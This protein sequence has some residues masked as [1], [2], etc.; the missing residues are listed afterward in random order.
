MAEQTLFYR[1]FGSATGFNN[2]ITTGSGVHGRVGFGNLAR[3]YAALNRKNMRHTDNKGYPLCYVV[4]IEAIGKTDQAHQI[5]IFT[6]PETWVLKNAVRKWHAARNQMLERVDQLGKVGEYGKTIRPYLTVANAT[7]GYITPTLGKANH[8]TTYTGGGG[9]PSYSEATSAAVTGTTMNLGEWTHTQIAASTDHEDQAAGNYPVDT[10][11]LVLTGD[12]N[13]NEGSDNSGARQFS[14][15]SMMR[16]YLESR[17]NAAAI[18]Q[19]TDGQ[20]T[21]QA[22][23]NPLINLMSDR[24]SVGEVKEIVQDMQREKPPYDLFTATSD[25]A[26]STNDSLD[27]VN[28]CLLST[29]TSY[30][31][32]KEV[33]RIPMGLFHIR[34]SASAAIGSTSSVPEMRIRLLGIDKCQG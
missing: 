2:P 18:I 1:E 30:L 16:S 19:T 6:A 27:L 23:P 10:Y 34:A 12:H 8:E 13:A 5:E 33:I 4:E 21:I 24:P 11:N 25:N 31:K 3:D 15:V 26:L 22:E 14:H 7:Q 32:D 9:S 20:G 29:T 28:K 17:R